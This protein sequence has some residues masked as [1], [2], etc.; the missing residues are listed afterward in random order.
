MTGSNTFQHVPTRSR[1]YP[2]TPRGLVGKA[3][4]DLIAYAGL[5]PK[6]AGDIARNL[7]EPTIKRIIGGRANIS[8]PS[9]QALAGVLQLPINFFLYILDGNREALEALTMPTHVREYLPGLLGPTPPPPR[10]G[11]ATA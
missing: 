10:R 7:S 8:E 4:S 2:E 1:T 5:T 6:T 11:R 9:L 3:A